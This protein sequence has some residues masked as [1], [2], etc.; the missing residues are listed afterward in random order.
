MWGVAV[1]DAAER[2]FDQ[3]SGVRTALMA[4]IRTAA[5]ATL[6]D[7]AAYRHE[8]ALQSLKTR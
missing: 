3:P 6:A 8:Q 4:R 2:D 1:G 7:I 5:D